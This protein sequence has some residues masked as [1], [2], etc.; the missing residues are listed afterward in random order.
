MKIPLLAIIFLAALVSGYGVFANVL[1]SVTA[2]PA[3]V[4]VQRVVLV[5]P[6]GT[7]MAPGGVPVAYEI[8]ADDVANL[9]AAQATF[10]YNPTLFSVDS[11]VLGPDFGGCF[12]AVNDDVRGPWSWA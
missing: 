9:A 7:T 4:T 5:G 3:S 8:Q 6:T 11:V 12:H 1:Q 2:L 10:T